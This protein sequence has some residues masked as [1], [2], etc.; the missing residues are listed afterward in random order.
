MN[1]SKN[2]GY[3]ILLILGGLLIL[4]GL[5]SPNLGKLSILDNSNATYVKPSDPVLLQL[6]E[7][8]VSSLGNGGDDALALANLYN[9]IATLIEI[10]QDIIKNTE[11]IRE[12]NR[13]SGHMLNLGIKDK[14]PNL[15]ESA[16][17]LVVTYIGD[18]NAALS[19]E[20]R[21]KSVEAFRALAWACREGSK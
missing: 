8:V 15:G 11:E 9:D 10:D 18:D 12:A 21:K 2:N 14:Y 4:I 17:K 1:Q 5:V 19:P 13:I 3:T 16:N 6:T 20:L 7:S